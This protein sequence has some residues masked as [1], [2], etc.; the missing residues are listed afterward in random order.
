MQN[1][2]ITLFIV[3]ANVVAILLIYHSFSK[4]IEK[5][6]K[7]LY[8]MIS[9]GVIYIIVLIIYSLSS[10]G[11]ESSIASVGRDFVT[12]SF[13]PI[14]AII[15]LPFLIRSFNKSKEKEITNEQLNFRT[16]VIGIITLII[17]ISEFFYFRN[18]QENAKELA[19][20]INEQIM[21]N[22]E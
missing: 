2:F 5:T 14:N 1:L 18:I 12:F 8:T 9:V 11:Y 20:Q 17:L 4:K 6:K 3:I 21:K 22:E 10:I 13:V 19:K 15:I 7:M 16:I